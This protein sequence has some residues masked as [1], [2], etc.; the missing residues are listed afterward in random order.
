MA[1]RCPLSLVVMTQIFSPVFSVNADRSREPSFSASLFSSASSAKR[2]PS[3]SEHAGRETLLA[4]VPLFSVPQ[5]R[6][7]LRPLAPA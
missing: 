2:R 3:R 5:L 4:I 6:Q 1:A 7:A